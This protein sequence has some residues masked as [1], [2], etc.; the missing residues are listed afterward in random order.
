MKYSSS[1]L[2]EMFG[3]SKETIRLWSITFKQFL[4]P[5]ASSGLKGQRRFYDENDLEVFALIR[6]MKMRKITFDEIALSLANG[7]RGEPPITSSALATRQ[8]QVL[9]LQLQLDDTKRLLAKESERAITAEGQ[10]ALL[11]RQLAA[12]QT[13]LREA[14]KR[15]GKLEG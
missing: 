7:E 8:D 14:Y 5:T 15:I 13:E 1:D 4:S 2:M 6:D 12:A 9:I 3:Q 11:E 10:V